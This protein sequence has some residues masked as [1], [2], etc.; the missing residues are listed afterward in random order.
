MRFCQSP[1]TSCVP[2]CSGAS[3]KFLEG[4]AMRSCSSKGVKLAKTSYSAI[5]IRIPRLYASGGLTRKAGGVPDVDTSVT[6]SR[7]RS[8][9]NKGSVRMHQGMLS[10][11]MKV[12]SRSRF[13]LLR[14]SKEKS[15]DNT[16]PA[17]LWSC[18]ANQ[19]PLTL[20]I[21]SVDKLAHA[22]GYL[23]ISGHCSWRENSRVRCLTC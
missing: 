4:A 12:D 6:R 1:L 2:S 20:L 10:V 15:L 5:S 22:W 8:R 21:S 17:D 11:G 16:A 14:S 7:I 3:P 23:E 18:R 13:S 19:S 9:G